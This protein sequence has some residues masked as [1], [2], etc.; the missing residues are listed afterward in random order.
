MTDLDFE[1]QRLL[2]AARRGL[3]PG[4]VDQRRVR[5]TITAALAAGAAAM[6]LSNSASAVSGGFAGG[7]VRGALVK[8]T[9][10][11]PKAV[12]AAAALGASAVAGYH[13]GLDAGRD[14]GRL[15]A[16]E[17]AAAQAAAQLADRA[18]AAR[19]ASSREAAVATDGNTATER[20]TATDGDTAGKQPARIGHPIPKSAP[21]SGQRTAGAA[22]GAVSEDDPV[23]AELRALR[24][25][26]R[27]LR[28]NNARLA[29]VL[30]DELDASNAANRLTEERA[31]ARSVARCLSAP[32]ARA[33]VLS[34]YVERYPNSVYI[35]RVE[36]ACGRTDPA[37][38]Q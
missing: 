28:D 23:K 34:G 9:T 13:V 10:W 35:K 20:D 21:A 18:G 19:R 24:R 11:A 8:L 32:D 16:T 27:A 30:L 25:I 1:E 38:T 15:A 22:N 26:E 29:F 3:S 6:T 5:L 31:A 36:Q 7:A 33:D 12:V 37:A 17:A 14:A 2:D 4:A